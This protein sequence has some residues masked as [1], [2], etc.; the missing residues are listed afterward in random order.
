MEKV[1]LTTSDN[2]TII[3]NHYKVLPPSPGVTLLHMMPSTKE[4]YHA[5]AQKL[6]EAGIGA[7]AIDL[8]GHGESEGGPK[9]YESFSDEEHQKSIEDVKASIDFQK[10]EP[11]SPILIAGASIGANLALQYIASSPEVEKAI[12]LSPGINYKGIESLPL[13]KKV[14]PKKAIYILASKDDAR[15]LGSAD[16][17]AQEIFNALECKKEIKIFE[18]GGHGTDILEAHP[19]MMDS[20]IEWLKS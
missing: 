7:L 20:L 11:H 9:G 1:K 15:R 6:N 3:G 4:S 19:E 8:R 10:N 13:A 17:Q 2:K 14:S 18:T 12:L 16:Q 5:F